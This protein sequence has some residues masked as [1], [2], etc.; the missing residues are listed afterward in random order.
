[1]IISPPGHASTTYFT[2]AT[3]NT[4]M[5]RTPFRRGHVHAECEA[6]DIVTVGPGGAYEPAIEGTE[7]AI[8]VVSGS[9]T[10]TT[11]TEQ[12][13]DE[14]QVETGDVMPIGEM[15][16]SPRVTTTAGC[17]LLWLSVHPRRVTENL[18]PRRPNR[19]HSAAN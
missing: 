5:V 11:M 8:F 19:S 12:G 7:S 3:R 1:M 9:A 14:H 6:C 13:A 18:P 10:I 4:I 15:P 2:N 17:V 16:R